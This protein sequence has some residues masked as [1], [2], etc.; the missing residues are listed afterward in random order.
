M[1]LL[2]PATRKLLVDHMNGRL[3][4]L[5]FRHHL[6]G[7]CIFWV[8]F[9]VSPEFRQSLVCFASLDVDDRQRVMRTLL[10]QLD[11]VLEVGNALIEERRR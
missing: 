7:N 6:R 8:R 4:R 9:Q 1:R 5:Q 2:S 3:P 10:C 11:H